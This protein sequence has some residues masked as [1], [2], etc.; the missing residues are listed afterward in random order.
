MGFFGF[1]K[2]KKEE[3]VIEIERV[4]SEKLEEWVVKKSSVLDI[5][6]KSF[7]DSVNFRISKLIKE[8]KDGIV[9]VEKIDWDKIKAEERLK[10]IVKENLDNYICYL[11]VLI[12]DLDGLQEFDEDKMRGIFLVFEKKARMN[13]QK[14]TILIGNELAAFHEL[15][16]NFFK[17]FDRKKKENLELMNNVLVMK[18]LKRKLISL[19]QSDKMIMEINGLIKSNL[20]ENDNLKREIEKFREELLGVKKGEEYRSWEKMKEMLNKD[21][22]NLDIEIRTLKEMIDFKILAR[23]WHKNE[24]EMDAI[25]SYRF[26][27]K[28]GFQKDSGILKK[29]IQGLDDDA[30]VNC[31]FEEVLGLFEKVKGCK[32]SRS[33]GFEIE[34]KIDKLVNE[35]DG[36]G[37]NKI[38]E[39]KK[40]EKLVFGRGKILGEIGDYLKK[41]G[42]EFVFEKV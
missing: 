30:K 7:Q 12:A 39:E 40:V 36:L 11:G 42:V 13:Y 16:K 6:E 22:T 1:L 27:F 31:K 32:L 25:N 18:R 19:D 8:L 35:V 3:K 33:P 38:K 4:N 2:R 26:N 9:V 24:E 21:K 5:E 34:G 14:A 41:F 28:E 37:R 15:I 10:L 29:L 23:V 17:D 20:D